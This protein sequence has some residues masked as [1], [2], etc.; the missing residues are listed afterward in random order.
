M[1]PIAPTALGIAVIG[2]CAALGYFV[3][4]EKR[5]QRSYTVPAVSIATAAPLQDVFLELREPEGYVALTGAHREPTVLSCD[6][7]SF[8]RKAEPNVPLLVFKST[9]WRIWA[10]GKAQVL[11]LHLPVLGCR[12]SITFKLS[13]AG[14]GEVAVEGEVTIKGP[15][16]CLWM[17]ARIA[18]PQVDDRMR[19]LKER[20]ETNFPNATVAEPADPAN[21]VE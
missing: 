16:A 8:T 1:P 5:V 6:L 4:F 10:D 18:R 9:V 13:E 17:V 2:S 20:F 12:C 15:L 21:S 19:L 7:L 14:A 3:L 11:E